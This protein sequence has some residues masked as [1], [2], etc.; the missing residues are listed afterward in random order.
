M[1]SWSGV[2]L[3]CGEIVGQGWSGRGI[4]GL[5]PV[6]TIALAALAVQVHGR[7]LNITS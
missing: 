2:R 1:A 4:T 6:G 5:L 7:E 3:V